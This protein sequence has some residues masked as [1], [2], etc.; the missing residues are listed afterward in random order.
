MKIAKW[1][2]SLALRLPVSALR[3]AGLD[4]GSEVDVIPTEEGVLIKKASKPRY[5]LDEL[6][7]QSSPED[8]RLPEQEHKDFLESPPVGREII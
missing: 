4:E 5:S 7:A 2:N 8:F 3:P 6:L 1:G